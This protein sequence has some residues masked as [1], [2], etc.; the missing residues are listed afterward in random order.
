MAYWKCI[1]YFSVYNALVP[2]FYDSLQYDAMVYY[3]FFV[4]R[5]ARYPL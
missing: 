4:D 2:F 1:R 5:L 3:R